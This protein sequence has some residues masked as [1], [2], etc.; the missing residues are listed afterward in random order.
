MISI[1]LKKRFCKDFGIKISIYDEP[2]FEERLDTLGYKKE[3]HD[4]CSMIA[5]KFNYNEYD[6]FEYASDVQNKAISIIKDSSYLLSGESYD[7]LMNENKDF[8]KKYQLPHADI[9]KEQNIGKKFLSIDMS[10]ANFSVLVLLSKIYDGDFNHNDFSYDA[11]M[12]NITE[13]DYF[14]KSKYSRQVIFGNC[15]SK[16]LQGIEKNVM[17]HFVDQLEKAFHGISRSVVCLNND[18]IVLDMSEAETYAKLCDIQNF[19][20]AFTYHQE[21]VPLHINYFKLGKAYGTGTY[22]KQ[23]LVENKTPELK[24]NNPI[25]TLFVT[26]T[27]NNIPFTENDKVFY[28]E[29]GPAK[30]LEYPEITISFEPIQN[31][32]TSVELTNDE[33]ELEF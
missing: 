18:E 30:L 9:Y 13:L 32:E 6:F 15:N 2:F 25:D 24:C 22:L 4:F 19:I 10:K 28:S 7:V 29:F 16:R 31:K 23:D 11:F 26:K 14:S 33:D 5:Q 21:S 20:E 17:F 1:S 12:K 3:Y 8:C 27:L